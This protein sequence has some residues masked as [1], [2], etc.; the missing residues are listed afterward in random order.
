MGEMNESL[1][2]LENL[3]LLN[4]NNSIILNLIA[5]IYLSNNFISKSLNFY[6]DSIKLNS[7]NLRNY[8]SILYLM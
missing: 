8:D 4:P 7:N 6:F 5:D 1:I 2:I 3:K